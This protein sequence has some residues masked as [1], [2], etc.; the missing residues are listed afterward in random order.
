MVRREKGSKI[1]VS[2]F[3]TYIFKR[4]YSYLVRYRRY[5]D[6]FIMSHVYSFINSENL[7]EVFLGDY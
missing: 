7:E 3:R 4:M 6:L 2:N 5:L 1:T